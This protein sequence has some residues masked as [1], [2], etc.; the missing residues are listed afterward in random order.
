M[1]QAP[2]PGSKRLLRV[3]SLFINLDRVSFIEQSEGLIRVVFEE[4]HADV[5]DANGKK[6]GS[7]DLQNEVIIDDLESVQAPGAVAIFQL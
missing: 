3:K 6:T 7:D 1:P 5:F 2:G 4:K